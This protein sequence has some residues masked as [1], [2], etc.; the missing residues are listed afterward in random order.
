MIRTTS[1][2]NAITLVMATIYAL[3]AGL[4]VLVPESY[5]GLAQIW[6]NGL[7]LQAVQ[8][9]TPLTWGA[10]VFGLFAAAVATWVVTY[11]VAGMY[12]YFAQREQMAERHHRE[13]V[14]A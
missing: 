14:A 4:A 7:N 10:F 5:T 9:T 2:A 13:Y 1:L 12:N 11:T 3:R 6:L 8:T